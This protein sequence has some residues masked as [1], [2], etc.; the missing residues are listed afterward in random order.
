MQWVP[1]YEY[2]DFPHALEVARE[3]ISKRPELKNAVADVLDLMVAEVNDGG[4]YVHEEELAVDDLLEMLR[5][6]TLNSKG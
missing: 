1:E 3:V 2:S 6:A 4:S 5:N